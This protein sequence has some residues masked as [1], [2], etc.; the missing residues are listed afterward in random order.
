MRHA[1]ST[2][3]SA[4]SAD[5][6]RTARSLDGSKRSVSAAAQKYKG[7]FSRYGSPLKCGSIQ[8]PVVTMDC[9]MPA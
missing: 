6:I 4:D 3:P 9:A 7:G 1:S 8:S 5:Q 2:V